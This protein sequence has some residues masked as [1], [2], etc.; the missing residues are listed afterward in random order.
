[1][2]SS[3]GKIHIKGSQLKNKKQ[4]RHGYV[5]N[6]FIYCTLFLIAVAIITFYG[7]HFLSLYI[8][9]AGVSKN[10]ISLE[11]YGRFAHLSICLKFCSSSLYLPLFC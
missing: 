3:Q 11:K 1:M 2:P 4:K 7:F 9:E 8:S 6:N 10:L 5:F